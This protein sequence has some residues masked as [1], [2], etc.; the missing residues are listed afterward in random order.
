MGPNNCVRIR[1]SRTGVVVFLRLVTIMINRIIKH[2]TSDWY[3][4]EFCSKELRTKLLNKA[5]YD[6]GL[7]DNLITAISILIKDKHFIMGP[8]ATDYMITLDSMYAC[9]HLDNCEGFEAGAIWG[10]TKV[11]DNVKKYVLGD[12]RP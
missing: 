7:F 12:I 3:M 10:A 11:Y 5:P 4:L 1:Q 6:K 9:G 2:N 8:N